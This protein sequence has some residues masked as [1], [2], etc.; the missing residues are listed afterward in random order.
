MRIWNRFAKCDRDPPPRHRTRAWQTL[1]WYDCA[2]LV[3]QTRSGVQPFKSWCG[4]ARHAALI[5]SRS[6]ARSV[7]CFHPLCRI[8]L[9]TSWWSNRSL[10]KCR[11]TV[12]TDCSTHWPAWNQ[13]RLQS[14]RSHARPGQLNSAFWSLSLVSLQID[15][16]SRETSRD[17]ANWQEFLTGRILERH[18]RH[19]Q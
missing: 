6:P 10:L 9:R 1:V 18:D 16:L 2:R 17:L 4:F 3:Q 13:S 12:A 14:F 19:L 5:E 15:T 8:N 7:W 11:H